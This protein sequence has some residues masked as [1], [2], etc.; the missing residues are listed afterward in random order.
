MSI[1]WPESGAVLLVGPLDK[2]STKTADNIEKLAFSHAKKVLTSGSQQHSVLFDSGTHT[3]FLYVHPQVNS[4]WIKID[5]IRELINWAQGKPQLAT[6]KIAVISPAHTMNLQAANALLKTLEESSL[7][8]L[9]ILIT[10]KP[11]LIPATI[12]SRCF[13]IRISS[14]S[15]ALSSTLKETIV[16]DLNA[17][18]SKEE[19]VVVVSN[20]WLEQNPKEILECLF[21]LLNENLVNALKNHA[22][23]RNQR[24]WRFLENLISAKKL[25]E[26]PSQPNLQLLLESLLIEYCSLP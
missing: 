2:Y 12:R 25:L 1:K 26:T 19:E 17:L 18:K 11:S 16:K 6:K 9:F 5:Q 23:I 3:D 24:W 10:D 15:A 14:R 21:W 8:T 22:I 13:W 4:A 7:Q 20:R